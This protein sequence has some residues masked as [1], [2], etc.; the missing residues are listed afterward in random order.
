VAVNREELEKVATEL[1][2]GGMLTLEHI[3]RVFGQ[4]FWMLIV[5]SL[6]DASDAARAI[7]GALLRLSG[8]QKIKLAKKGH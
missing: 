3:G 4:D 5:Y 6:M 2:A 7:Q 8:G 1:D